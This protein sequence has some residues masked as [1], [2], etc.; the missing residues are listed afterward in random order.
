MAL[1]IVAVITGIAVSFTGGFQLS[2]ARAEQR[3]YAGQL[4]HYWLSMENFVIW[5]LKEDLKQDEEDHGG[6]NDHRKEL[7]STLQVEAP[8][9]AGLARGSLE[10]AQGRFNLNQLS[11]R[12]EPYNAN[13]NFAERFTESQQRFVRLIQTYPDATIDATEA[14]Q[15]TEAVIDWIDA[16]SD[17]T[18]IGGA[19]DTFYAGLDPQYRAANQLFASTSELRLVRGINKEL[20]EYLLPLV[21]AL[22]D[23]QAGLNINT[24]K[25][26]LLRTLG[27][28]ETNTPL[29]Q[30]DAQRIQEMVP[31]APTE[32]QTD[33]FERPPNADLEDGFEDIQEF[34]NSEAIE[35][36]FGLED[37][38]K[39]LVT[40]LTTGSR[41][42]ILSTEIEIGNV[43]RRA[44]SLVKRGT[45]PEEPSLVI[46]RGTSAAL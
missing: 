23:E 9:E 11:G 6:L 37:E 5:G 40:Q 30:E 12:P 26:E 29:D 45:T 25:I 46:R 19:E 28:Q 20:Y 14:E 16:D 38:E 27:D 44:Y 4:K 2:L 15:I 1:L 13:G 17:E 42:F 21:A 24:A 7:W 39:P 34:L 31:A 35:T 32:A 36:I 22:P 41:Y 43:K 10:D 18:G 3:F 33:E 8:F